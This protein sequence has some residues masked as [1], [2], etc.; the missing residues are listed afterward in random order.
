MTTNKFTRRGF[1]A[2][3]GA[4][5]AV[6]ALPRLS[7]QASAAP[8]SPTNPLDGI[9][10][11][12]IW[13]QEN[14]SFDHYFGTY[15]GVAGYSDPKARAGIFTQAD[16]RG[17]NGEIQPFHLD[18]A[19]ADADCLADPAHSY[20]TQHQAWDNGALDAWG[21]AHAGDVDLSYMGYYTRADMPYYYGVADAWTLCDNY[22]CSVLG[23][24]TPNRLYAMS[25]FNDPNGL[26]GGP[27]QG[28]VAITSAAP[29]GSRTTW[30]L[31]SDQWKTY[32]ELL[33]DAGISW[34]VY[35]NPT[36]DNE[37]AVLPLFEQYYPQNYPA[38]SAMNA[39]A[40]ALQNLSTVPQ[41]PTDFLTDVA[42]GDLPAVSWI[43]P[44][45]V[46]SEHP[47]FAPQDGE[48]I[49][50]KVITALQA[51]P[52]WESTALF[53]TY[54]ENGGFFD[55]VP[56]PVP[57]AGT[58]D[59]FPVNQPTV[60]TGLGFR[61]PMLVISP[62]SRGGFVCHDTFD[63]TSLLRFLEAK[64]GVEAPNISTWRRQTAGDLTAAFNFAAPADPSV[65]DI[66]GAVANASDQPEECL[67]EEIDSLPYPTPSATG[68][69]PQEAGTR[70]SPS[71]LNGAAPGGPSPVLPEFEHP[72]MAVALGTGLAGT[73]WLLR[74]RRLVAAQAAA[75][76]SDGDDH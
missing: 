25:G 57:P 62:F 35:G 7:G 39:R 41:F 6:I 61:V 45:A 27:V 22:F 66:P 29:S 31:Y 14:R 76:Q 60:P 73:A 23:E 1:I 54:D 16:P 75:D 30:G 47:S 38:G 37:Y 46:E 18:T 68:A 56:P 34:K 20:S 49:L 32:P 40:A 2:G 69:P 64:F 55:H 65:P 36:G 72:A 50:D 59:E 17:P 53:F 71:G 51:S 67:A 9:E 3:A 10:H 48:N 70:P 13:I 42:S 28:T 8:A 11:V 44:N 58:A 12:I 52:Q 33:F 5:G 4:A 26:Y 43:I 21:A 63:H 74:R 15:P 19:Q 24:T